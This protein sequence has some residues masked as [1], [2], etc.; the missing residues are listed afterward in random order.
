MHMG[1]QLGL[2]THL[3]NLH[4]THSWA[5]V[6]SWVHPTAWYPPRRSTVPQTHWLHWP[7]WHSICPT[8]CQHPPCWSWVPTAWGVSRLQSKPIVHPRTWLSGNFRPGIDLGSLDNGGTRIL[9]TCMSLGSLSI[10]FQPVFSG[11]IFSDMNPRSFHM[12]KIWDWR[13]QVS[14]HP[15]FVQALGIIS[16]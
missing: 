6:N 10:C 3:L 11:Q 13:H 8:D 2:G 16:F 15:M 1:F 14:I 7:P 12:G 9:H 5:W 4:P